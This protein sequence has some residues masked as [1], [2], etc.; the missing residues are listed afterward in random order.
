MPVRRAGEIER[1]PASVN[2]AA[3][4]G[5]GDGPAKQNI[6]GWRGWGPPDKKPPKI[7]QPCPS[8]PFALTFVA[9]Q[10]PVC[11]TVKDKNGR[12]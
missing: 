2:A 12:C 9:S 11:P 1:V 7:P 10:P 4:F 3:G 8:P 5:L 6:R